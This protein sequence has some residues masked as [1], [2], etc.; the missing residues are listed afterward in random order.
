MRNVRSRVAL[1]SSLAVVCGCRTGADRPAGA[2][3]AAASVGVE[4]APFDVDGV[5]RR[6]RLAVRRQGAALAAGHGGHAVEVE[7]GRVAFRPREGALSGAA[8]ALETTA[9]G[10]E[11][12]AR[13]ALGAASIDDQ[14][15]V[16]RAGGGG[17]TETL[18]NGERG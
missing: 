4:R 8:L 14:G 7:G 16:V 13:V 9:L 15:R 2:E 5:I 18:A 12:A 11:G 1:L 3:R 17:V 10:R 6:A